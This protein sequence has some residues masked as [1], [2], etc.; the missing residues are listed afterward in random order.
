MNSCREFETLLSL[1]A[2]AELEAEQAGTLEKHLAGCANCRR[3]V[4]SYQRLS[5]QMGQLHPPAIPENVFAD[6]NAGVADKIARG[7]SWRVRVVALI[8][9][10][11]S[12]YSRQRTMVWTS[13]LVLILAGT[14]TASYFARMAAPIQPTLTELL[15]NRDW[16]GLYYE[17]SSPLS[18]TARLHEPVPAGLLL[19]VLHEL[20]EAAGHDRRL[21]AGLEQILSQVP[22]LKHKTTGVSQSANRIGVIAADGIRILQRNNSSRTSMAPVERSLSQI[23]PHQ[24]ITLNE[25]IARTK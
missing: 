21:R 13:L 6:F 22:L 24:E 23:P 18:R 17:L 25:L 12:Y 5:R 8:A 4:A 15:Q 16:A 1:Y 11:A 7:E 14:F 2:N 20:R 9:V 3:E 19:T 10:V